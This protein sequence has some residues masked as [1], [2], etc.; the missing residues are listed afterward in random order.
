VQ[1]DARPDDEG[2]IRAWAGEGWALALCTGAQG[3]RWWSE[4]PRTVR[5]WLLQDLRK[6]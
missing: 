4:E 6:A 1:L 2:E 3:A 5:N